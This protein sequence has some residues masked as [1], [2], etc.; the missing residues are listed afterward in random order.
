MPK[1]AQLHLVLD[2][3]ILEALKEEAFQRD[4]SVSELCRQKL[5]GDSQLTR[6][7]QTVS[8]IRI[9]LCGECQ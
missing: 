9:K 5:S 3:E 7:E 2:S 6:I 8:Q 4:I 1:N